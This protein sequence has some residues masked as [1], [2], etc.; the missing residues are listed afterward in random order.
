MTKAKTSAG[1]DKKFIHLAEHIASWSKERG[2]KV[3]AIIVGPDR[4]IRATGFNG[5]P[6][7]VDDD[8]EARHSREDGEKY[9]WST[10]A[11]IN[12][13]CNAARIGVPLKDCTIYLSL[14]LYPCVDCAKAIIQ[15]GIAEVVAPPP[16]FKD[17]QWGESFK[18]AQIMFK[19]GGVKVRFLKG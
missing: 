9:L 8:I 19:E 11:E 18:R 12:A 17:P 5:W 2:R 3:G 7:G 1:W 14:S 15:S 6:R 16:D 10:H 4:E 13:I